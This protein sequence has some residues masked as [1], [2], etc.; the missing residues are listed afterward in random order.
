[1]IGHVN[2]YRVPDGELMSNEYRVPDEGSARRVHG[3]ETACAW[4]G[5]RRTLGCGYN[6]TRCTARWLDANHSD[7]PRDIDRHLEASGLALQVVRLRVPILHFTVGEDKEAALPLGCDGHA[8]RRGGNLLL[9]NVEP[10]AGH[11]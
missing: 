3:V 2:E 9:E 1:M 11:L 4:R 6:E 7:A 10:A 5:L 8:G